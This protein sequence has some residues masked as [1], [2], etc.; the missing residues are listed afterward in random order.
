[1]DYYVDHTS[2]FPHNTGIQRCVR[3]I[4]AAL[5]KAGVPLR[6]VVWDRQRNDLALADREGLDHLARF[7]GPPADAWQTD[8]NEDVPP[9]DHRWLIIVE[10]VRG[11]NNPSANDLHRAA[12]RRG[13]RVAWV[14]HD[15]IPLRWVHLYGASAAQTAASHQLYMEGLGRADLVLANSQASAQ[16]LRAFLLQQGLRLDH[17]QALPLA[18]EFPG[19][20][21]GVTTALAAHQPYRLLAVGSLERRKNHTALLKAIAWLI[22]QHQFDAEL[23][24]VGWANDPLVVATL[25]RALVLGLPCRWYEAVD[26]QRLTE[27]YQW[28]DATVVASLDEG[29][30][31]PVAESLWHG[32]PCLTT[33]EGALAELVEGGGCW[34]FTSPAWRNLAQGLQQWLSDAKLRAHISLEVTLRPERGWSD[35][36]EELLQKLR[37]YS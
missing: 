18:L 15:A 25:R 16:Q 5:L 30:G 24:L 35:Y 7:N 1:M 2:R 4:A 31:L 21:R 17:V 23:I 26:D 37:E 33:T 3:L 14:F 20:T 28:C 36:S 19:V 27:L 11:L 10:L 22:C 34:S 9:P 13:L 8:P 12:G 32:K 29:F 6:P